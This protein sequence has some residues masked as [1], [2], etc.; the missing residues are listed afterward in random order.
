MAAAGRGGGPRTPYQPS[1]TGGAG[2]T[3]PIAGSPN[4][5]APPTT[6]DSSAI[7]DAAKIAALVLGGGA[8]MGAAGYGAYRAA[9][10]L[11]PEISPRPTPGSSVP[12]MSEVGTNVPGMEATSMPP[13]VA[14]PPEAQVTP[15]DTAMNRAVPQVPGDLNPVARPGSLD[16]TPPRGPVSPVAGAEPPVIPLPPRVTPTDVAMPAPTTSTTLRGVPSARVVPPRV[17]ARLNLR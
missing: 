6:G 11:N 2:D 17:R 5:S 13:S 8:G 4:T 14:P 16:M 3:T 12:P 7:G 9:D 10:R 15:L 1:G